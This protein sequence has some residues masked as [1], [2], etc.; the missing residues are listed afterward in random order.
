VGAVEQWDWAAARAGDGE[1][2]GRVFDEHRDRVYRHAL[3]LVDTVADAEDVTAA[4]FLELWR[5]RA[6]VRIVDGSVLAWLLVTAT[7]A[8][9]NLRRSQLRHRRLLA[10]LPRGEERAPDPADVLDGLSPA[11]AV[12]LRALP[13]ADLQLVT[14]VI[15]EGFSI[16]EAATALGIT[17]AA[18]KARL[19]R[20][21]GRV[22]T[23]MSA[24]VPGGAR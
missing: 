12:S 10:R 14:L 11:L 19:H 13:L 15:V 20:A 6:D 24:L 4:A 5:R 3:R 2:F 17:P 1:A 7:N 21:R 18:A 9:R 22:R 16:A 23:T 8:A